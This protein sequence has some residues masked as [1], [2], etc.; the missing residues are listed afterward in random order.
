MIIG[1]TQ[2]LGQVRTSFFQAQEQ[3]TIGTI[4]KR[5]FKEA[6]T[7][8]KKSHTET[9]IGANAVSVSYAAVELA[10][11]IFGDLKEKHVT[12]VGGRKNGKTSDSKLQGSGAIK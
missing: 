2:I 1:E 7:V 8:A 6:I 9:D 4:F 3:D 5:L 12:I 11:K 10:K